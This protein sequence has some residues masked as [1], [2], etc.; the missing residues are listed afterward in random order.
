MLK[1]GLKPAEG[2]EYLKGMAVMGKNRLT[3]FPESWADS[4]GD[5]ASN[6]RD[7]RLKA[8]L[9]RAG[10]TV[11]AESSES[12]GSMGKGKP[13]GWTVG[14]MLPTMDTVNE[15]IAELKSSA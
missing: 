10:P 13:Y 11:S 4:F 15:M 7:E 1:N 9:K 12:L 5:N 3:I 14:L 6:N 8:Y 2:W